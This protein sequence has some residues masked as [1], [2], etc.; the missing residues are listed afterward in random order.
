MMFFHVLK[1]FRYIVKFC[2]QNTLIYHVYNAGFF[3]KIALKFYSLFSS[4]INRY[5]Q[6]QYLF[7]FK[8]ID[9][10]HSLCFQFKIFGDNTLNNL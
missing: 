2:C 3:D 9:G 1:Y 7:I 6:R 5:F 4:I 10:L 8:N